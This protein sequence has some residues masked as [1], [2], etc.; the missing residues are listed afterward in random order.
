MKKRLTRLAG[1]ALAGVLTVGGVWGAAPTVHAAGSGFSDVKSSHWA[2]GSIAAGVA[3]GYVEGYANGTFKP[4]ASVTRAEFVKMVVAAMKL[5]VGSESGKW[6]TPYITAA[7]K[8]GLYESGDFANN[9]AG[10]NKTMTREEMARIAARA[11]GETSKEDDKWMYL[12]TKKGL[13]TGVGKG[14]IALDGLSTRAQSIVIIER[15]LSANAG[16]KLSVDKYAVG[17]AEIAWHG[18]NIFT[19]MPEMWVTTESDVKQAGKSSVEEMWNESK[20][21]IISKDGLYQG[22]LEALVAID[23]ADPNDP[24]LKLLPNIN[25]LKWYNN[26]PS[27]DNLLIKDQKNSY[28]LFFKGGVTYNKDTKKYT[29]YKKYNS[30]TMLTFRIDG[31][32]SPDRE[33]FFNGKLNKTASVYRES[34]PDVPAIIIPKKG[35]IQLSNDLVVRLETPTGGTRFSDSEILRLRGIQP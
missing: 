15:I 32:N 33:A 18:T 2:A 29:P 31:F 17:S 23:L 13:I 1:L 20:M 11:A 7:T 6:Y 21:T 19:V 14:E 10:W 26:R 5:E 28:I 24:N 35:T 4:D 3:K 16:K 27:V 9:E 30:Q 8:A 12:A 34:W 25:T 22:K